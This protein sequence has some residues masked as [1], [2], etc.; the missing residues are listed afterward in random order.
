MER[1]RA[2]PTAMDI[3]HCESQPQKKACRLETLRIDQD[4]RISSRTR[5]QGTIR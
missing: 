3:I 1:T 4:G 5:A 2:C